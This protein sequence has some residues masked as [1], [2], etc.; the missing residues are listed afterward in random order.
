[1]RK[2]Q[3]K[4]FIRFCSKELVDK[5]HRLG[6]RSGEGFWYSNTLTLLICEPDKYR[7]LDDEMGNAESLVKKGYI[8]CKMNEELF[9]ALANMGRVKNQWYTC[10]QDHITYNM[11]EYKIGDMLCCDSDK[12]NINK[13]APSWRLATAEEIVGMFEHKINVKREYILCAAIKRKEPKTY[14][15]YWKDTNDICN[16]EIGYRHHDIF[17]RFGDEV[18]NKPHDQGFYTSLGRF[19]NR[20]E[21]MKIAFEAGQVTAEKVLMNGKFCNLYS[22]DL[23]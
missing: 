17:Q 12:A 23:Y 1:M 16:I 10:I 15:P 11:N 3:V 22:E 14:E 2:K 18:S 19:V 4:C 9:I 13:F 8:D 7:C 21:A 20:K 5:L 6:G